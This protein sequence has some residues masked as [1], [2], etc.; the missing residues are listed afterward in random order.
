MFFFCVRFVCCLACA[1]LG[2]F[3][4]Q[5]A[6]AAA[7]RMQPLPQRL[8]ETGL[9]LPGSAQIVNPAHIAFSP[10]YPLWSDGTRKRRWLSLPRGGTV[11]AS[12]P[13]AWQ[14]PVGTR[15]WKEFAYERAVETRYIERL[16]DGSWRFAS[17]VWRED[18]SDADLAPE[19]G[20]GA[21][22]VPGDG[23]RRY[24]IPARSDCR[25]CHE[26]APSPVLG[27]SALQLSPDRDPLAPHADVLTSEASDL[28][29]L[30]ARGV[31]RNLP[32]SLLEAPPRIASA[33]PVER[34]ALGYLHGNCGHCHSDSRAG[35]S[36]VPVDIVLAQSVSNGPAAVERVRQSLRDVPGR[37]RHL[38]AM[39]VVV[40]G[41]ATRS[42]LVLRMGSRNPQLQMPPLGTRV[43]DREGLALVSQWISHHLEPRKT[44]QP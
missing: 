9:Y 40:A 24:D 25:A 18:G 2:L 6:Q 15:L 33:L 19:A 14:F 21:Q 28:R 16:R 11:D 5:P 1:L 32:A 8:S 20:L 30:Q 7:R 38:A 26:S 41:D 22:P 31:L 37:F 34:A 12:R 39:Q 3:L 44:L 36:P 43:P 13:D 29:T 10:Q 27:F 35:G 4:A 42:T 17:Y 23:T